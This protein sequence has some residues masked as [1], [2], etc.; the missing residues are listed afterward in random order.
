VEEKEMKMNK[1]MASL[2]AVSLL[3]ATPAW[4]VESNGGA[5]V[6][7]VNWAKVELTPAVMKT[8]EGLPELLP[9]TKG[10]TNLSVDWVV[11]NVVTVGLSKKDESIARTTPDGQKLDLRTLAIVDVDLITGELLRVRLSDIRANDGTPQATD[12]VIKKTATEYLKKLQNKDD[13]EYQ[14]VSVWH[15]D[16]Y[17]L[18][19]K[20]RLETQVNFRA[21]VAGDASKAHYVEVLVNAQGAFLSYIKETKPVAYDSWYVAEIDK[22]VKPNDVLPD[23]ARI[24]LEK[25]KQI[26]PVMNQY[27]VEVIVAGKDG[28]AKVNLQKDKTNRYPSVYMKFNE[29]GSF[30]NLNVNE[31]G[32]QPATD[33]LAKEKAAAFLKT[34]LG[35]AASQ[36]QLKEVRREEHTANLQSGTMQWATK[37]VRFFNEDTSRW[38][39]VEVSS[40]G[41]ICGFW[42]P[43]QENG[44]P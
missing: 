43:A 36:F 3:S 30:Y 35:E 25:M 39:E 31:P 27:P 38:M 7:I 28:T 8:I 11:K 18:G 22:R 26:L 15:T 33:Q 6:T 21:P 10:Y 2:I 23:Q 9:Q 12:D 40:A 4:A 29:D 1:W 5:S 32:I 41:E 37:M 42:G 17:E 24:N 19:K 20:R 13:G 16:T 34:Y 44:L 14:L